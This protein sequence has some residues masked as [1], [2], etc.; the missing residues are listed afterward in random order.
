MSFHT[1]EKILKELLKIQEILIWQQ[2]IVID[3]KLTKIFF[4]SDVHGSDLCFRKFINAGSFYKVTHLILGGDITGKMIIPIVEKSGGGY[5]LEEGG[6]QRE[7]SKEQIDSIIRELDDFGYYPYVCSQS[8]FA[9]LSSSES[10]RSELFTTLIKEKL[11]KWMKLAEERL[12]NSGI[13]CYISPGNDDTLEIDEIL[14]TS[15]YVI[16]PEEK[17]IDLDGEHEM[18]TL[19]YANRTP[20]NTHRE[21]DEDMLELK[22]M[23]LA[24]QVDD[25]SCGLFNLHVPPYNTILDKAPELDGTLK[26][27]NTGAGV[28]LISVGSKAVRNCIEK[29]QPLAGLHGH[30][31]ES[32]GRCVIGRTV[33]FNPGSEYSTGR[34]NGLLLNLKGNKIASYMFTSG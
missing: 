26:P 23:K 33:C 18:I 5:I 17:V 24:D 10:K 7:I 9:E 29:Y 2:F 15:S 20:W 6:K 34:L 30:I 19:G 22:I 21:C 27:V 11:V 25:L 1:T 13:K 12:K 32:M 4:I 31:H 3:M 16:N 28:N 14:D 8:E